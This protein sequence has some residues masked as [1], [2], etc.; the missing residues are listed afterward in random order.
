MIEFDEVSKTYQELQVLDRLTFTIRPG[1][2]VGILGPSGSG[3]TTILRLIAGLIE[4]DSGIV[5]VDGNSIG[6]VFQEPRLLPWRRVIDNVRI[7]LLSRNRPQDVADSLA[8]LWI[9][10]VGLAEFENY[11]PAQLSGGMQ[12]RVSLARAFATE[13]EILLLDEPFSSLD[14]DRKGDLLHI[15]KTMIDEKSVTAVY[16]THD[17]T[18]LLQIADRIFL[19]DETGRLEELD[20]SDRHQ[21]LFDYVADLLS[22]DLAKGALQSR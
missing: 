13:P 9:D 16:V 15:L 1:E 19:F 6:Y 2:I 22:F 3:K 4:P 21:L 12:Q 11:Y 5:R 8:R 17:L 7:P 14:S 20:L 10:K 18:E